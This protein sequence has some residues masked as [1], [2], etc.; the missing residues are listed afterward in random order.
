MKRLLATLTIMA[1]LFLSIQNTIAAPNIKLCINANCKKP[2]LIEVTEDCWSDIK[3]IFATPFS[4][5]KDEQDNMVNAI[6]LIEFD[7]YHSL[8]R[9][10]GEQNSAEDLYAENSNKNN[11]RNIKN[12]LNV[13]L[14][15]HMIEHHLMRRTTTEKGWS[16]EQTTGLMLQSL[17][18]AK[19]YLLSSDTSQLGDSAIIKPYKAS[20]IINFDPPA[21]KINNSLDNDD[22]E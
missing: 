1:F 22:F 20:S 9:A 3:E 10:V 18:S 2:Q 8:A 21:E 12:I 4:T 5:A 6:A 16:G 19:L 17:S 14:D 13:L 11:Y 15:H 7:I